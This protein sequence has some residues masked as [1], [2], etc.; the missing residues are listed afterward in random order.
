MSQRPDEAGPAAAA[1]PTANGANRISAFTAMIGIGVIGAS[2]PFLMPIFVGAMIDHLG[3]SAR[4]AGLIAAVELT[5]MGA[6]TL[7]MTVLVNRWNRRAI[8]FAGLAIFLIGNLLASLVGSGAD[9]FLP[10]AIARALSGM[11]S[12]I[13]LS[14]MKAT[15]AATRNPV[16][17][18]GIYSIVLLVVASVAFPSMPLVLAKWGTTGAYLVAATLVLPG[19]ALLRWFPPRGLAPAVREGGERPVVW[20]VLLALV[21]MLV[22]FIAQ[23]SV[24]AYLERMGVASGLDVAVVGKILG[25]AALAGMAGAALVSWLNV[26]IGRAKPVFFGVLCSVASLLLL[27]QGWGAEAYAVAA[28]TL[29]LTFFFSGP[30]LLGTMAALDTQGRVVV[31]GLVMQSIGGAAGPALAGLIIVGDNYLSVGWLGIICYVLSLAMFLPVMLRL[32]RGKGGNAAEPVMA[33]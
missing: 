3:F 11:G 8:V 5:S 9:A 6:A 2:M 25:G 1:T 15:V 10:L 30:Y 16:R 12:G 26:R 4:D 14:T 19:L 7:T 33:E 29:N 13:L 27:V 21:A 31:M 32:D 23:G 24:W 18:F 17:I 28:M 20:P 22:Y